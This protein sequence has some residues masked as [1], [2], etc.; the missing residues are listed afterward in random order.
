MCNV[1]ALTRHDAMVQPTRQ[2]SERT[3]HTMGK[4]PRTV[5][6]PVCDPPPVEWHDFFCG[7]GLAAYGARAAGFAVAQGVDNDPLA[8]LAFARNFP[9]AGALNLRLGPGDEAP[10]L[11]EGE[12]W[13]H[14]ACDADEAV[15]ETELI[16]P[17][18]QPFCTHQH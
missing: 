17:H 12:W 4:R 1:A 9:E 3:V 7:G 8:L 5:E 11:E 6:P 18:R 10:I 14:D 2:K 15:V 13:S 16:R